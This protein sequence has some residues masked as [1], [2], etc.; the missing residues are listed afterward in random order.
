MDGLG[1]LRAQMEDL[2]KVG[3]LQE[4]FPR[5]AIA[6]LRGEGPRYLCN[7]PVCADVLGGI[8]EYSGGLVLNTPLAEHTGVALQSRGDG[9]LQIERMSPVGN[10]GAAPFRVRLADLIEEGRCFDGSPSTL[11]EK[12]VA[13]CAGTIVEALRTGLFSSVRSGLSL[14]VNHDFARIAG[15]S[16]YPALSSAILVALAGMTQEVLEPN[17]AAHLAV[18]AENQ[19]AGG[20]VGPAAALCGLLGQA[21]HLMQFRCDNRTLGGVLELP[22]SLRI[23]SIECNCQESGH[24]D[25]Y[26][27]ARTAT[28]MGRLIVDRIVKHDGILGDQWDGH[29]SRISVNDFVEKIRDRLPTRITGAEFLS[30]FGD[31]GDPYSQVNPRQVYKVRSRTEHHV[32][33]HFRARQFVETISRGIRMGDRNAFIEAGS[34]MSA[35][36][37]SSGQRCGLGS[38]RANSLVNSL[39]KKG[40]AE[41]IFGVRVAG[42]GCG[43]MI[44]VLMEQSPGAVQ[45]IA[46][47]LEA[48]VRDYNLPARILDGSLVGA[49]VSGASRI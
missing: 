8:V 5:W 39:R 21:H 47:S 29:L 31:S 34:L 42:Q 15:V 41:G 28:F 30:H 18:V 40:P 13:C 46:D 26:V 49:M 36:H 45:A 20:A 38:V 27:Q 7:A 10:N 37:W 19:W 25:K 3:H 32:Y 9:L 4:D 1:L 11:L 35:S 23:L 43:G 24:D 12:V 22:D 6:H 33:E 44:V 17:I 16:P 14:V 48:H 2:K